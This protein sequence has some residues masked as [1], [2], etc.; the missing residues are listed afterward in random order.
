MEESIRKCSSELH[1]ENEAISFC[2]ECKIYICNKCEKFHSE[3]FQ[4]HQHYKLEKDK[5]INEIFTDICK[6]KNHPH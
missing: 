1:K 6:E 5:D 3:L 4:K 2:Y